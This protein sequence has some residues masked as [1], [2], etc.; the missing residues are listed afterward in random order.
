M[1]R[2]KFRS[3]IRV[4][5]LY[6]EIRTKQKSQT[7]PLN[8]NSDSGFLNFLHRDI[9]DKSY[10]QGQKLFSWWW[11]YVPETCRAKNISIKLPSCIKL[12]V[13]FIL[14]DKSRPGVQ[15]LYFLSINATLNARLI[16]KKHAIRRRLFRFGCSHK[17]TL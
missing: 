17:C 16:T 12:A 7:S 6:N 9:I 14:S 13:H 4:S 3:L 15:P 11:A 1:V 10:Q 2:L 8:N 5:N